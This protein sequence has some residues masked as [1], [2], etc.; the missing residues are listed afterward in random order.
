[1]RV[2]KDG[3]ALGISTSGPVEVALLHE[4]RER[5]IQA[6][7]QA[8]EAL[9]TSIEAALTREALT[10]RDVELLAVCTGP[11]SFTGLR[12]GVAF[13][14]SLA[15]SRRLPIVGVSAYD[16]AACHIDQFPLV[17][18]AKG[19]RNFYYARV[20]TSPDAAY[21]FFHGDRAAV[22]QAVAQLASS[23][24]HT[25]VLAGADF[26][27]LPP[28]ERARRVA[29]L[30]RQAY[31]AGRAH[32]WRDIAIDYGQRPNAVINW[33]KRQPRTQEGQPFERRELPADEGPA[34]PA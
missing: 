18:V 31:K 4:S 10:V 29:Q 6:P 25:P 12:I 27:L 23:T 15:Q 22:E 2:N 17:V 14:K 30:G 7:G 26:S 34:A 32:G 3:W 5:I 16:V 20:S 9:L 24:G 21:E 8:L 11:G 1:M 33:E 19:K 28:G 13:A